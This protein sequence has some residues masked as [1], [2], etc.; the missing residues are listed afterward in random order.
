[1][2]SK[3]LVVL[4]RFLNLEMLMAFQIL[5][6]CPTSKCY[7]SY[8]CPRLACSCPENIIF[9]EGSEKVVKLCNEK[10]CCCLDDGICSIGNPKVVV[11]C[12]GHIFFK[13]H[14][15]LALGNSTI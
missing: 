15:Q 13:M 4:S 11:Y 10:L 5:L 1:M 8:F 3:I 14:N 12:I 2:R 6:F 7:H 9:A